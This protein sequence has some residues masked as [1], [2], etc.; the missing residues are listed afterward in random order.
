MASRQRPRAAAADPSGTGSPRAGYRSRATR[1]PG[2]RTSRAGG[3]GP[4]ASIRHDARPGYGKPVRA[5]A[6]LTHER[7]VLGPA[8]VVIA[9]HVAAVAVQHLAGGM[10][11]G[12]PDRRS[13]AVR[14]Y[15]ALDLIGRRGHPPHEVRRKH[16]RAGRLRVQQPRRSLV[17][18]IWNRSHRMCA[19]CCPTRQ[20]LST[21]GADVPRPRGLELTL[22]FKE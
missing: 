3:I 5:H 4:V 19:T 1:R 7:Q 22:H 17:S 20:R 2:A 6:Q 15:G 16:A 13:A 9:G 12:V 18:Q 14:V 8:V 11:E 10:A 21:P